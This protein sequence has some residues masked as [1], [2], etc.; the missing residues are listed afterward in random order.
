[1][2]PTKLLSDKTANMAARVALYR[3]FASAAPKLQSR[4]ELQKLPSSDL[5]CTRLSSGL[6]VATVENDNPVA[7]I[8][9]IFKAGTRYETTENRGVVHR[10]RNLIGLSTN[11]RTAID[12]NYHVASIGAILTSTATRDHLSFD[13]QFARRNVGEAFRLLDDLTSE[14]FHVLQHELEWSKA[15]MLRELYLLKDNWPAYTLEKL[16]K[17][18]YRRNG[19]GHLLLSPKYAIGKHKVDQ[20]VDYASE[21][22]T[23][24]NAA[25][26]ATGVDSDDVLKWASDFFPLAKGSSVA[27]P[28]KAKFYAGELRKQKP[29]NLATVHIGAQSVGLNDV[30]ATLAQTVLANVLGTGPAIKWSEG[31]QTRLAKAVRKSTSNPFYVSASNIGYDGSGIFTIL[32]TSQWDDSAAV[33]KAALGELRSIASQGVKDQELEGAKNRVKYRLLSLAEN[34]DYVVE[35][36]AVQAAVRQSDACLSSEQ[37]KSVDAVTAADVQQAAKNIVSGKLAMGAIG[38]LDKTPYVDELG[39]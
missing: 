20:L 3:P 23:T 28:E 31:G 27:A 9:L 15:Q 6:F 34:D 24:G 10:L 35:D 39:S 16:H 7:R 30:K 4:G 18:A 22:F 19:L 37:A 8:S 14:P 11:K 32:Y 26:A 2:F 36:L 33:A 12:F 5:K 17:A 29:S 38:R 25:L 13:I 21:H 1:M